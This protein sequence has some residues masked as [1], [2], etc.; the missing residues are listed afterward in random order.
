M[1]VFG[2]TKGKEWTVSLEDLKKSFDKH[3]DQIKNL[4]Y[5]ILDVK[6]TKWH[7]DYGQVFKERVK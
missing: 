4:E 6:I 7:D 3:L 1:P 2:G 5:D